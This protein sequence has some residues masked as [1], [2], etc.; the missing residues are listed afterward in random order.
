MYLL[1]AAAE[2]LWG[3]LKGHSAAYC[4]TLARGVSCS[5]C[6]SDADGENNQVTEVLRR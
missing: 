4:K 2:L 5:V 6:A 3:P 1:I